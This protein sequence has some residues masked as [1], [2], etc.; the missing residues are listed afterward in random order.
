[1]AIGSA[2]EIGSVFTTIHGF[3][4]DHW[5]EIVGDDLMGGY[6]TLCFADPVR[7]QKIHQGWLDNP[8]SGVVESTT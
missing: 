6:G 4:F 1:M 5:R 3:D 2:P 8:V 7:M